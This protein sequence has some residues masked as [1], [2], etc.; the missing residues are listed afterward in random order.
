MAIRRGQR[1]EDHFTQV[2]NDTVRDDRL[3]YRA[4]GILVVVLSHHDDWATSSE[5]LARRGT[6]GRDAIRTALQELEDAGYL[7]RERRQDE[8]GRWSTQQVIYDRPRTDG[9]PALFAPPTTENQASVLQSSE[10]QASIE[11]HVEDSGTTYRADDPVATPLKPKVPGQIV[12]EKVWEHTQGMA[13][14]MAVRQIAARALKVKVRGATP[15]PEEVAQVMC[16]AYDAERPLT[17]TVVGQALNRA[18]GFKATNEDHWASGGQ[19]QGGG[20]YD[21]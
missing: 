8:R 12:A 14:F 21:G 6:E 18:A 9:Q 10:N 7:V 11:D 1:P 16:Q 5:E 17:L 15:T 13:N 4:R 2:H 19:F 3:S 20:H